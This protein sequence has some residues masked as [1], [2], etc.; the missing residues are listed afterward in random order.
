[1]SLVDLSYVDD[2]L[3]LLFLDG[4]LNRFMFY[5]S[6]F[7]SDLPGDFYLYS[8]TLGLVDN[9]LNSLYNFEYSFFS[10]LKLLS[11]FST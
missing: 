10:Y 6:L 2:L 5:F 1:M 11:Y 7:S 4:L 9:P 8:Y 3:W